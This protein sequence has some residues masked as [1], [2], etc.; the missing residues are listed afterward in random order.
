MVDFMTRNNTSLSYQEN[1][2]VLPFAKKSTEINRYIFSKWNK[3][4]QCL[5]MSFEFYH[6]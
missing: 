1:E 5:I 4:K 2:I 3:P 6:T